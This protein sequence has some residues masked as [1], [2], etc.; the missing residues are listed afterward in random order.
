MAI[1]TRLLRTF[2]ICSTFFLLILFFLPNQRRGIPQSLLP[3][4]G[5][6]Q[7]LQHL[8]HL[9]SFGAVNQIPV[10]GFGTS[11]AD[12]SATRRAVLAALRA[13][14]R[15]ID[16][17][18]AY[19][20]E[21]EVGNAIAASSVPRP[22][23]WITSKLW[24]T[25]HAPDRVR[26]AIEKTLKDLGT[27]QLDL[28]LMHWPIAFT[29]SNSFFSTSTPSINTSAS[30]LET[31][32]A[33][34]DLVRANLTRFIGVS[35]FAKHEMETLLQNAEIRPFAHEFEI[36]PYLSQKDF[37]GWN[38]QQKINVIA[39]SP[40][41]NMNPAYDSPDVTPLL[42]EQRIIDRAAIREATAAQIVLSWAIRRGTIIIPKS[43]HEHRIRENLGALYTSMSGQDL[44]VIDLLDKKLRLNN[45]GKEWG[46]ELF[47]DLDG[48]TKKE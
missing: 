13:G 31:W 8:L 18:A 6:G 43:T 3:Y 27:D 34:E 16:A 40:L 37:V 38:Q 23:I 24:N 21:K 25:E 5:S 17:A 44:T 30:I 47:S 2:I 48:A 12:K 10:I 15:H 4:E 33:M 46:V 45:P 41:G 7:S 39:Y 26:P 14:Y 22:E 9:P 19:G 32:R 28:Y 29:P 42:K 35:N 1:G 36:H 20:N 11:R